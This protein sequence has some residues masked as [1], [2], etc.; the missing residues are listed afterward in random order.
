MIEMPALF[1]RMSIFF[2]P[3]K[4]TASLTSC[5]GPPTVDRSASIARHLSA[6]AVP[7]ERTRSRTLSASAFCA[8][9]G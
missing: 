3:I 5:A 8:G 1:T 4:R 7:V 9:H 6:A 2:P